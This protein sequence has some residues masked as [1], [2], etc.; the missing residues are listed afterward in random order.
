MATFAAHQKDVV[1]MQ[2]AFE[3]LLAIAKI[4]HRKIKDPPR[5]QDMLSNK[6]HFVHKFMHEFVHDFVHEFVR[7]TEF[8]YACDVHAT[9]TG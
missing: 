5:K 4:P 1:M 7:V 9:P 8:V 3:G 6:T 2:G